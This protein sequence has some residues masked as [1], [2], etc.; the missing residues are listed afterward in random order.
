MKRISIYILIVFMLLQQ[1]CTC[2]KDDLAQFNSELLLRFRYTL[3]NKHVN[4]FGSDVKSVTI[5]IFDSNNKYVNNF[6]E[7]GNKL[8]NDYV[9]HIQLPKGKYSAIVYG[10]PFTTYS[11]GELDNQS[12]ILNKTLRKGITDIN[13]FR[14]ELQHIA[15]ADTYLYPAN[16]PD[17]LYVGLATNAIS[18][19]DNKNITDIELIKNT[20]KIKVKITGTDFINS[21]LSVYIT[22]LNGRYK[23]DNNID[24]KHGTLKYTPIATSSQPNYIEVDLKTMRL[25][26]GQL[27]MLTIKNSVTNET[28]YNEEMISQILLNPQYSSQADFD[29]AD[30]FI[31]EI[32]IVNNIVISITINGWI[33]NNINSDI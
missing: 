2:V 33:I 27:S 28:L 14:A 25:M 19:I 29:C 5:Y 20:K 21:P 26:L 1:S 12:N 13:D 15:N 3:N 4:L 24:I 16:T 9:M 7:Q 23:F 17:D 32:L 6:S 22:A 10:G 31:F 30:E 11:V 18:D 8:T